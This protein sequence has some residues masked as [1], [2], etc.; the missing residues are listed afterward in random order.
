[1]P[2][3]PKTILVVDD[4]VEIR[5]AL[6]DVLEE[7]GYEVRSAANGVEALAMLRR[8]LASP[9]SLIVLDLMMPQMNGWQF[10]EAQRADPALAPI[11]VLVISAAALELGRASIAGNPRLRKP[12]ELAHLLEAVARYAR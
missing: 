4:D 5:E 2:E 10:C 12:I 1:M 7:E 6:T 9:P 11:P 3:P 8:Y